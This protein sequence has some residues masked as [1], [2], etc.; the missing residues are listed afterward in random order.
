MKVVRYMMLAALLCAVP[1]SAQVTDSVTIEVL[2]LP[3]SVEIDYPARA[4]IGDTISVAYQIIG[5][6]GEPSAGVAVWTATPPDAA[7]ILEQTD[8][9]VTVV[10]NQRGLVRL[11]VEVSLLDRLVIGG[12][13]VD[14]SRNLETGDPIPAGTF[15]WS[16]EGQFYVDAI[17]SEI[18]MCT[19]AFAGSRV[20][21]VSSDDCYQNLPALTG[22]VLPP[23]SGI[24]RAEATQ[25]RP[26]LL[27]PY[28][29]ADSKQPAHAGGLVPWWA[30]E[31]L[32][33]GAGPT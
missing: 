6:D 32:R 28:L 2:S 31:A 9:T 30:T 19:A 21:A 12:R 27:A 22:G 3:S 15:Q 13:Y 23:L 8:S 25:M 29:N 1:A 20:V 14:P 7:T 18:Q 5:E 16:T 17:G 24:R 11:I 26:V 10:L 33:A 4:Y